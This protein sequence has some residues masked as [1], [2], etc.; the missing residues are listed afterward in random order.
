LQ[1][2]SPAYKKIVA[3]FARAS[4]IHRGNGYDNAPSE[5]FWASLKSE[6]VYRRR[7][8][9]REQTGLAI[10]KYIEVL[11]PQRTQARLDCLS[12]AEFTQRFYLDRTAV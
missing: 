5:S 6:L 12:P 9:T 10:T 11:Q 4:M 7:F 2:C 3:Q 8:T 1:Y